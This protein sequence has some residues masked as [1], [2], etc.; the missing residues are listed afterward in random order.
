ML[1]VLVLTTNL[2]I[3]NGV[4]SFLMNYAQSLDRTQITMDF[5]LYQT[6][7]SPYLKQL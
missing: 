1:K 4:S 6:V 2:R 7:P 3:A 5:A